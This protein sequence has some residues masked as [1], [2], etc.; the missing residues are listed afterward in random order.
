MAVA[1]AV[2]ATVV[3]TIVVIDRPDRLEYWIPIAHEETVLRSADRSSTPSLEGVLEAYRHRDAE[4]AIEALQRVDIPP[5]EIMATKLRA[6]YLASAYENAG[7]HDDALAT[8]RSMNVA[9]LPVQWRRQARWVEYCALVRT[10]QA[11]EA[12]AVLETLVDEPGEIGER[13]RAEEQ[14]LR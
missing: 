3:A 12:R 2:L 14:R 13:A 11:D 7:R 8:L 5:E 4:G 10:G 9:S 6:L 1:A